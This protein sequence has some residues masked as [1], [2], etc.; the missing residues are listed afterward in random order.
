MKRSELL[1]ASSKLLLDCALVVLSFALAYIFRASLEFNPFSDEIPIG[2]YV[3]YGVAMLPVWI[4]ILAS[5]GLYSLKSNYGPF[6]LF[7]KILISSLAAVMVLAVVIFLTK[8]LFFS[9]IILALTW[10]FSF[11]LIYLE[12]LMIGTVQNFFLKKG[13][14]IHRLILVG[15]GDSSSAIARDLRAGEKDRYKITGLITTDGNFG[16]LEPLGSISEIGEVLDHQDADDLILT[17]SNL[18]RQEV[19]TLMRYCSDHKIDYKFIPDIYALISVNF[20]PNMIGKLPVMEMSVMP[21][22]GWG[23][24]TKRFF[25]IVFSVFFLI[26]LSPV[27][28]AIAILVKLTS[29][30]PV[31]FRQQRVGRDGK[32]FYFYKF[33]SMHE[34]EK[35]HTGDHWTTNAEVENHATPVGKILRKTNLDE[36]PQLW[37][38]IL[39]DMSFVGPRPEQPKLVEKFEKEY[40]QYFRRHRVKS[41]LTGWA[42]VNGLKGDTSI[43]ERVK[44]DIY[45]IENWSLWF[46]LKIILKTMG[47]VIYEAIAGKFEY[48]NRP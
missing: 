15:A 16:D 31:L 14:G 34:R 37:N 42:A 39:G 10:I 24:I 1:F 22:D 5:N 21:L 12:R 25:D 45:Y 46:D 19:A 33:R 36:L 48:R 9:R 40:P 44:Y 26:V 27:M 35:L 28:L 30:G 17:E 38:I 20:R 8:S 18:P 4:A 41:G 11:L 29:K 7:Y 43:E 23:R 6:T 3:L 47:L 13:I 32:E 2:R